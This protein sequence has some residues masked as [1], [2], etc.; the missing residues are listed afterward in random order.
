M[1][2]LHGL[3]APQVLF[4]EDF[5][6]SRSPRLLRFQRSL[7]LFSKGF[8]PARGRLPSH[9]T[10]A[11]NRFRGIVLWMTVFLKNY[12]EAG[13]MGQEPVVVRYLPFRESI[14]QVKDILIQNRGS[15]WLQSDTLGSLHLPWNLVRRP[16]K[17]WFSCWDLVFPTRL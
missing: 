2:I 11:Q 13:T 1:P 17:Y 9:Q 16:Q 7:P 8:L 6:P 4:W 5:R 12:Q 10:P 14:E 15:Y 3:Q